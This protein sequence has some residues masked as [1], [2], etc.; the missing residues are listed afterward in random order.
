MPLSDTALRAAKPRL[1]PYKAFDT[2]GLFVLVTPAGGRLWRLRY[3]HLGKEKLLALGAH[4]D[5]GLKEAREGRDAARRLLAAGKDPMVEKRRIAVAAKLGSENTFATVASEVI[6]KSRKEGRAPAT[7]EKMEWFAR[8]LAPALGG[9]PIADIE[10]HEVLEAMRR[11]EAH[12]RHETARKALGF[13]GRVFRH[14]IVTARA[15]TNPAAHLLGALTAPK[16]RHFAALIEPAAVGGL[17]RAIDTYDGQPTTRLALQLIAHTFA[18]PGELRQATW[19]EFDFE[20]AVW[21]IPAVR[22]KMRQDH[23]VPLSRQALAIVR[24][25]QKL[26]GGG[27]LV[28]PSIRTSRRPMSENTLTAALRRMGFEKHEMSAHGFRATASSL[29][30][31]AGQWSPDAI[32]RALAHGERDA[33]RGAYHR[34]AHWQERVQMAQWWS[35]YL[36]RLRAGGEVVQLPAR[37]G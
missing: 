26:S 14:A 23:A 31:Q 29:L 36:D 1:K 5:V 4:P 8:L 22:M 32:E 18:R 30:N 15:S 10:P 25:A 3:R 16:P 6:A 34:G 21:R 37:S 13:A 28:F 9:R 7:I 20:A 35:D 17:L 24:E 19:A 27:A 11:V 33:V 2:G 12:G